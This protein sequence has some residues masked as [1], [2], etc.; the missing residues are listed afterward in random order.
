MDAKISYSFETSISERASGYAKASGSVKIEPIPLSEILAT[1][2]PLPISGTR[3]ET[4]RA[5]R[6]ARGVRVP[7]AAGWLSSAPEGARAGR[8]RGNSTGRR[9]FPEQ[10]D[11]ALGVRLLEVRSVGGDELRAF[12]V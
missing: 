11:A 12:V 6:A 9:E 3:L 8:A 2:M 4:Q 7:H 5:P 1:H 10:D